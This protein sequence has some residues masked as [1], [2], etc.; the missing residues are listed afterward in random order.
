M[1]FWCIFLPS[2]Y[3]PAIFFCI[4][5]F[6]V[7]HPTKILPFFL[8]KVIQTSLRTCATDNETSAVP[9]VEDPIQS[10]S[11]DGRNIIA[12]SVGYATKVLFSSRLVIR[13]GF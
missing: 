5:S 2:I 12:L 7:K 9:S 4:L 6:E 10:S 3:L 13:D 11:P 8:P 1:S